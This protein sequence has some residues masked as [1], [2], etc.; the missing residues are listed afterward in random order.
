MT[1]KYRLFRKPGNLNEVTDLLKSKGAK[2]VEMEFGMVCLD[3]EFM[4][5]APASKYVAQT[6]G[7]KFEYTHIFKDKSFLDF[8]GFRSPYSE[9]EHSTILQQL[10]KQK[11]ELENFG[12]HTQIYMPSKFG[13]KP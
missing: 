2:S 8:L 9:V 12:I 6:E 13:S 3:M 7:G 11:E 10:E 4:E 1:L 5:F